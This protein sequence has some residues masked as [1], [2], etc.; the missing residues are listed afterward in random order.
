MT[1]LFSVIALAVTLSV[2]L[3]AQTTSLTGTVTD[4]TGAVIP[5][6][7]ISILNADTGFQREDKSDTQGRYTMESLPPG[8]YKLT[9]KAPGFAEM[10]REVRLYVNQPLSVPIVFEK[11]GSTS[12]TV[13]VE[14]YA[15]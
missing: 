13:S 12:T 7:V 11:I 8:T 5:N 3:F 4:P 6:A 1:R 10:N 2:S 15:A 14:A 9:A